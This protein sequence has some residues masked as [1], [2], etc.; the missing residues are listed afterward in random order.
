MAMHSLWMRYFSHSLIHPLITFTIPRKY[1]PLRKTNIG[2]VS[3]SKG[4]TTHRRKFLIVIG[5]SSLWEASE[6][7]DSVPQNTKLECWGDFVFNLLHTPSHSMSPWH[8]TKIQGLFHETE[9][10]TNL[11]SGERLLVFFTRPITTFFRGL[12]KLYVYVLITFHVAVIKIPDRK[13][14][15]EERCVLFHGYKGWQSFT[16]GRGN[17]RSWSMLGVWDAGSSQC[18]HHDVE[19]WP[20]TRRGCDLQILVSMTCFPHPQDPTTSQNT[21]TGWGTETLKTQACKETLQFPTQLVRGK[22]EKCV[23]PCLR[24]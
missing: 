5:K 14:W 6:R 7:R 24:W 16:W 19:S 21:A 18:G 1:A 10:Q 13:S 4:F 15:R 11:K 17:R 9:L 8:L 3:T 20:R 12:G 2:G 22:K 23:E